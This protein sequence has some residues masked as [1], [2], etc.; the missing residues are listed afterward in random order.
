M[1]TQESKIKDHALDTVNIFL[2]LLV[3]QNDV[4]RIFQV[5]MRVA[6]EM[7]G[8]NERSVFTIELL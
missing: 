6:S 3:D 4:T 1:T 8:S 7:T 2:I 5:T